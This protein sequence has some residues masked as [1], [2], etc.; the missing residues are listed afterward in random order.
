MQLCARDQAVQMHPLLTWMI[1]SSPAWV[2]GTAQVLLLLNLRPHL[3]L[4]LHLQRWEK[5]QR[6]EMR[7]LRGP[8]LVLW[9]RRSAVA[10][11]ATELVAPR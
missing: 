11:A 3:L 7:L 9:Q 6:S 8:D 2:C 10:S 4:L 1:R 5:C